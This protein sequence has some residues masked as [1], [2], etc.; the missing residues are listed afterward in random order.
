MRVLVSSARAFHKIYGIKYDEIKR[1]RPGGGREPGRAA[2]PR[3]L[4]RPVR[5]AANC[6]AVFI[7]PLLVGI[8]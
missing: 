4:Q 6:G 3:G 8:W 5:G 7:F 1:F 2:F